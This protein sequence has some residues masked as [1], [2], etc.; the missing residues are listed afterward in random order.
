MTASAI[1]HAPKRNLNSRRW[2]AGV[3]SALTLAAVA[4][5]TLLAN[6]PADAATIE[7][8]ALSIAASKHGDPY[9]YGAAGPNRFDC[10]GLTYYSFKHAG[11]NLPRTAQAQYNSVRHISRASLRPG[12]LVFFHSGSYVYHVGI[13]A[14]YN[15]IWHAPH[16]G[17]YVKLERI[18][19]GSVWFGR[20]G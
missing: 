14:G 16:S 1:T 9:S 18:W 6:S 20:I 19:T 15:R 3:T 13:Y 8:K 4:G 7:A 12:D 10:S 2:R 5:S 17:S 11:K